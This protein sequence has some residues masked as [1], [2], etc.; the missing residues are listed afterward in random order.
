MKTG[1]IG[2]GAMGFS[3]AKNL[4]QAGLLVGVY[5]RNAVK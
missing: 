4:H 5:N 1:F 3:M 2:L